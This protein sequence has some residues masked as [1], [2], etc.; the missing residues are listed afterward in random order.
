[1][2][3]Q[4]G[5]EM[6]SSKFELDWDDSQ[7]IQA[8]SPKGLLIILSVTLLLKELQFNLMR[9]SKKEYLILKTQNNLI[10]RSSKVSFK[11]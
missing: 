6:S 7:A 11:I 9:E 10:P 2:L 3:K 8:K 4:N 1:M 5:L